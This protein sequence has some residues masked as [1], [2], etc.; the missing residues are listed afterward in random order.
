M[1]RK[2][3]SKGRVLGAQCLRAELQVLA[4]KGYLGQNRLCHLPQRAA[5]LS[6]RT[7]EEG[8]RRTIFCR[9]WG[10]QVSCRNHLKLLF[11]FFLGCLKRRQS[12]FEGHR[13][14]RRK[15]WNKPSPNHDRLISSLGSVPPRKRTTAPTCLRTN[16]SGQLQIQT[17][18]FLQRCT[19]LLYQPF[20]L[21]ETQFPQT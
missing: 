6:W 15:H 5:E 16:I 11:F 3:R 10:A 12:V 20:F 7:R 21:G 8:T 14:N 13:R 18:A 17:W 9:P 19:L 4:Q 2:N 1:Q